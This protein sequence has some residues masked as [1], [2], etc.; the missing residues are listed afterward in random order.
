RLPVLQNDAGRD[1]WGRDHNTHGFSQWVAGGGFKRGCVYGETDEF[2]HHAVKDVVN[3]YDWHATLL[4]NF[5]FNHEKLGFLRN[6]VNM[7]LTDAQGARVVNDIL[8]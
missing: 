5:G 4:H 7:T 8:A 3:H 1:K 6:G 2:G